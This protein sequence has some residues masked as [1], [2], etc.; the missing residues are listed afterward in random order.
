MLLNSRAVAAVLGLVTGGITMLFLGM[1]TKMQPAALFFSFVVVYSVAALSIYITLEFLIFRELNRLYSMVERMKKKDYK[2][3]KRTFKK[4]SFRPINRLGDQMV[5]FASRK[6][7][8][9]DELKSLETYRREFLADVGHELK[10]P[11]FAAQGFIDTLIDGAVD[12]PE[13]RDKFLKKASKSLDGL[14]ELLEELDT[15]SQLEL[16]AINMRPIRVEVRSLVNDVFEQ[17]EDRAAKRNTILK[18]ESRPDRPIFVLADPMRIRQVLNNLVENAIKYGNDNGRITISLDAEKEFVNLSVRDD[19]PGIAGEHLKRI[20]ERFYR[21]EK[22]RN[23]NMGGVG[24]GLAI[25][26]HIVEAHESKITVNS[27]LGKG[28]SFSF[29]LRKAKAEPSITEAKEN[30]VSGRPGL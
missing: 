2:E 28:T 13:V 24:L 15:L 14:K 10:T 19:G 25:V 21:V 23:K 26:K 18:F 6:E 8:E 11:V 3:I 1:V 12:D 20:F 29:R 30:E 4:Y 5:K 9:I 7:E 17:L 27:K 16:G 22:S